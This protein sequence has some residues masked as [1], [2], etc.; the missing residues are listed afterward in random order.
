MNN[1]SSSG[2]VKRDF[3]RLTF[4]VIQMKKAQLGLESLTA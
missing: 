1:I 3:I 2:S 4:M